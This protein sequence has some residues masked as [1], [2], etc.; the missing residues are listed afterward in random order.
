MWCTVQTCGVFYTGSCRPW[1]ES[2][3]GTRSRYLNDYMPS[4]QLC[5][6]LNTS[7]GVLYRLVQA[8]GGKF[9]LHSGE[10]VGTTMCTLTLPS[11]VFFSISCGVLYRLVHA[12]GGKFFLHSREGVG[13]TV[14][15]D[16]SLG[17]VTKTPQGASIGRVHHLGTGPIGDELHPELAGVRAKLRGLRCL[18]VDG[19]PVR[20]QVSPSSSHSSFQ[21]L[22]LGIVVFT[23]LIFS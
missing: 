11:P 13:T 12:M 20:Q 22:Y 14:T 23:D 4:P 9:L 19:R 21:L 17:H 8:M 5:L 3:E 2:S 18:V 7:C 15:F 1:G 16:V 10:G 6:L